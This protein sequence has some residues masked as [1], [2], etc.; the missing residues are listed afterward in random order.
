LLGSVEGMTNKSPVLEILACVD[1]YA[2][3][4]E[5]RARSAKESVIP[6]LDKNATR[7][8]VETRKNWIVDG[9][10]LLFGRLREADTSQTGS[11]EQRDSLHLAAVIYTCLFGEVTGVLSQSRLRGIYPMIRSTGVLGM[12]SPPAILG[13]LIKAIS[14]ASW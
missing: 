7:I 5:K 4:G 14:H 2:G 3:K 6:F 10:V 8:R 12:M 9:R 13:K 1:G 11:D